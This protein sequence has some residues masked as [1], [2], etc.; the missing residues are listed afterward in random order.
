MKYNNFNASV[1]CPVGNLISITDFEE[2]DKKFQ[3]LEKNVKVGKVY[4]ET[5]RGGTM[6]SKEQM[7]KIIEFFVNKGIEVSGG[8]TTD[9]VYDPKEGGFSPQCYTSAEVKERMIKVVTLTA[10][11][12]D[13]F[14]LDDFYF[15]NCRCDS[16]IKAKGDRSWSEFRL[17]LMK[18]FSETVIV[19]TAKEV[20]P[21]VKAIIKFPNWY[22]HFQDAGYN[23]EDEP[24][25]FDYIYTGT[26]TRNPTYTQQH[27]PKYLSYFIMRYFENVAPNRNQGGWFDPYECTYNLTS[28]MEQGYLTLFAKA[29]EA[30]LFSL[31]SLIND[32]AFTAF[33][34]VIGQAFEDVDKYLSSLG[35]PIGAATYVPYH[36]FGEDFLHNY[37]GMC[38][39][40]LE[41]YPEYPKDAKTIFLTENAAHD[42]EIVSKMKESFNA[43]ADIIVTSGFVSR[44]GAAFQELAHVSFTGKKMIVNRYMCSSDGGVTVAGALESAK[45]IVLTQPQFFTNDVWQIAGGYGEDNNNPIIMKTKYSNGRLYIVTIPDDQGDLYHYPNAILNALRVIL[46]ENLPVVLEG[47]SRITLF[48]YDNDTFILRSFQPYITSASVIVKKENA[49]LT[50]LENGR[51]IK[52]EAVPSGTKFTLNLSSGVNYVMKFN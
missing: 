30:M 47:D 6:I 2:F 4:L 43:G 12:F 25:I 40:P 24:K 3:L 36:S 18:D 5:Y 1:Y 16:C 21:N 23:L 35:N 48:V 9:D 50:D 39:I 37:V 26:E 10:E 34:P 29:K 15:T 32:K 19:K 8:I 27:L 7:L 11:L 17:E 42:P 49:V 22:E 28:Y 41:P 20:N 51:T 13:E 38:G 46:S 44:L 45:N 14:I 33:P 52:G 31:G